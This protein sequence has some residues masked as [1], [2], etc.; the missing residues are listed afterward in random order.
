M[1]FGGF[2]GGA[3]MFGGGGG[4]RS[5]AAP[6]GGLPFAGIPSELQEGV[7]RLLEQE[8]EYPEPTAEFTYI[9]TDE[10]SRHLNLRQL[11]FRHWRLGVLAV[12]LVCIVSVAN[13]LGPKLIQYA[14]THGMPPHHHAMRVVALCAG[15]F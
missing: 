11:I 10:R 13:Q 6:G 7:D 5:A 2:G 8:P 15:L 1:S 9:N 3:P 14:I 12:L 4:P